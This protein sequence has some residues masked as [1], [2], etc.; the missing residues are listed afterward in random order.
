M[1]IDAE[2]P[3]HALSIE[4]TF[5]I[6]AA[7]AVAERA[8]GVAAKRPVSASVETTVIFAAALI[9]AVFFGD[10]RVAA[11]R[12]IPTAARSLRGLDIIAR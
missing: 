9:E 3:R 1:V 5:I 4:L 7:A 6:S 2:F 11:A 10:L 8:G 12:A